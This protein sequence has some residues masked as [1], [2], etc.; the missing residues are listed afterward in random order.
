LIGFHS[1][2]YISKRDMQQEGFASKINPKV[3]TIWRY[4]AWYDCFIP[5][6]QQLS[7]GEGDTKL[8]EI[9]TASGGKVYFKR[10]DQNPTGSH[11]ARSV[12]YRLSLLRQQGKAKAVI[13][14]SGN[15]ALAVAAYGVLTG[16]DYYILVSP[17][18][19]IGKLA[20]LAELA[21]GCSRLHLAVSSRAMRF[22][23]YLSAKHGMANLRPSLDDE[24]LVGFESIAYELYEQWQS[25]GEQHL[26]HIFTL[27]SSGS[28]LLGIK[29]GFDR[30]VQSGSLSSVPALHLVQTEDACGMAQAMGAA[31]LGAKTKEYQSQTVRN[32][33]VKQS[34]RTSQVIEAVQQTKGQAWI[35]SWAEIKA[36][37]AWL[38]HQ[39]IQISWEGCASLAAAVKLGQQAPLADRLGIV[40]ILSGQYYPEVKYDINKLPRLETIQQL[41]EWVGYS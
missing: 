4:A 34:A 7:L 26:G 27:S 41:E 20:K 10:E 1:L 19:Q 22:A 8:Q 11:K 18:T 2:Q 14:S 6:D 25:Q 12:A 29:Q 23:N 5:K 38:A 30:L 13:S 9:L 32:L 24:A 15:A 36:Q 3:N 37:Q 35:I 31:N 33:G 28:S 39:G 40:C 16:I 17:D 21:S